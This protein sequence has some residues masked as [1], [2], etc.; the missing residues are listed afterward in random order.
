MG[1]VTIWKFLRIPNLL[2]LIITQW[3]VYSFFFK[4]FLEFNPHTLSSL[5]LI[6]L[7]VTTALVASAGYVINNIRDFKLDATQKHKSFI[8]TPIKLHWAW[9]IYWLLVLTGALLSV[10]IANYADRNEALIWYPLATILLAWYS[11]QLK[12]SPLLGN[13]LVACFTSGVILLIPYAYWSEFIE[14]RN[15]DPLLWNRLF[16]SLILL[17]LFAFNINFVREIIKD[18]QDSSADAAAQCNSTAVYYGAS[19][20][21]KIALLFWCIHILIWMIHFYFNST[22]LFKWS[23]GIFVIIP[24]AYLSYS[25][26]LSLNEH[27]LNKL[28][29]GLKLYM[30]TGLLYWCIS[31]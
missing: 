14:L 29:L 1:F 3:L 22:T 13:V 18:I 6:L 26:V 16:Y 21:G 27:R 30:L 20:A 11:Y 31:V 7:S 15:G 17:S 4:P 12:C 28:S 10:F 19:T 5:H 2:I 25:I 24:V 23:T 9:R 8:P